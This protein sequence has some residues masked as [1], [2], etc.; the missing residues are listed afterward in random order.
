MDERKKSVKENVERTRDEEKDEKGRKVGKIYRT[1]RKDGRKMQE[2]RTYSR[3]KGMLEQERREGKS[4]KRK[5]VRFQINSGREGKQE[6]RK[7]G[8]Q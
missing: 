4:N 8:W 5:G 7:I 6:G 2:G 3:E 1:G